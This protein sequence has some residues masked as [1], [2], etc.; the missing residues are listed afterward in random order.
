M[1]GY[2]RYCDHEF[3]RD[4]ANCKICLHCHTRREYEQ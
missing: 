3:V 4:D 2:D 1:T